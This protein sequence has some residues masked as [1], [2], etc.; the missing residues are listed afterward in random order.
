[1]PKFIEK[2]KSHHVQLALA[3]GTSIIAMAVASRWLLPKPI[4]YLSQA[5]PP[6]LAVVYESV[7]RK[8]PDSRL[9]TTWYWI[10]A[11]GLTTV[12]VIALHL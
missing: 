11:I 8:R 9:C 2:I 10:L 6:F 1:M 12:L 4:G 7:C 5:F 3:V